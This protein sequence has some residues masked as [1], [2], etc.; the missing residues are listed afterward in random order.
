MEGVD[1]RGRRY[2]GCKKDCLMGK[3]CENIR[4]IRMARSL[5]QRALADELELDVSA[6]CNFERGK[7][8]LRMKDLPVIASVLGVE[9]IDLFTWPSRYTD[10]GSLLCADRNGVHLVGSAENGCGEAE[11]EPGR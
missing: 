3:L 5:P 2:V 9:V 4:E 8:D 7:R 6:V 11:K 1:E 10:T